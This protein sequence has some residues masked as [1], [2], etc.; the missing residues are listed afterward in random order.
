MNYERNLTRDK[1]SIGVN[2]QITIYPNHGQVLLCAFKF[3]GQNRTLANWSKDGEPVSMSITATGE[4]LCQIFL[5]VQ[6]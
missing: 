4:T 2:S 5:G 1:K 3:N 6:S